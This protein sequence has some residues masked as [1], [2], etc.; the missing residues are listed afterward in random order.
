MINDFLEFTSN[1]A[2]YKPND[3]ILLAVSGGKDSVAMV[4][5]FAKTNQKFSIAH[6][7]FGLRY[8]ESD[9]DER[10]VASMAKH[11]G[12]DFHSRSFETEQEAEKRGVSIQ[13]AARD[14]RYEWFG[15]LMHSNGFDYLATA[16][17]QNDS[18]ETVLFNLIKGTGIAGLHGIPIKREYFI[19]PLSFATRTQIDNFVE[20]NNLFW[21]EDSS[22]YSST[23]HR[24]L[25]RNEVVPLLKQ[26][27]PRLD[28]TFAD[29]LK[30]IQAIE[31]V[32][33]GY[34]KDLSSQ[35]IERSGEHLIIHFKSLQDS[36]HPEL[37]IYDIIRPYGFTFKQ[38][39]SLITKLDDVGKV[40]DSQTHRINVD[41]DRLILSPILKKSGHSVLISGDNG[42][43][44]NS[45][46]GLKWNKKSRKEYRIKAS[47]EMAALDFDKLKFP[48]RM[49]LWREG[50]FFYPLGM[51]HKKKI[52]DFLIDQKIPLNLKDE[53][54]VIADIDGEIVWV[55]GL[56]IDNRF[57]LTEGSQQVFEI[58]VR[59]DQD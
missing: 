8:D 22:N 14:L 52:S 17:H 49:R 11:Y 1:N 39:L 18:F 34:L 35:I 4:H 3:H 54:Y 46:W 13:M 56:R 25:I 55:V 45:H 48:L 53:T 44:V 19:R 59:H 24:N 38:A 16:H 6:C 21:R 27:N 5:L 31:K 47:N 26:I 43:W 12:V 15:E 29:T 51:D 33:N 57:K 30:R 9:G 42:S 40:F 20:Q 28:H 37:P 2:L 10:F 50:D 32:Y 58:Q 23:Y 36:E 7:N 41:R